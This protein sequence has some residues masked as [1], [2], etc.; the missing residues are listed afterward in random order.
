MLEN[1]KQKLVID[2]TKKDAV[3]LAIIAGVV[4]QIENYCDIKLTGK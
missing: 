2:N 1:L 4:A 3:L